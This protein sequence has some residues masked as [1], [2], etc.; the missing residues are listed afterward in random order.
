MG[1]SNNNEKNR[2]VNN[3]EDIH[4]DD[5][6]DEENGGDDDAADEEELPRKRPRRTQTSQQ[7]VSDSLTIIARRYHREDNDELNHNSNN[8]RYS[9]L[10]FRILPTTKMEKLFTKYDD[11]QERHIQQNVGLNNNAGRRLRPPVPL[12]PTTFLFGS[13]IVQPTDT[14]TSLGM[15]EHDMI[16]ATESAYI[17]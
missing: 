16:I 9:D 5:S 6:G 3:D 13:R 4:S 7:S 14:A 10:Y 17:E 1:R 2:S 15:T 11:I 12:P 8:R